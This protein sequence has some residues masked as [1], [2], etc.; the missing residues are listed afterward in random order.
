MDPYFVQAIVTLTVKGCNVGAVN[1]GACFPHGYMPVRIDVEQDAKGDNAKTTE[2]ITLIVKHEN[3][4][5]ESMYSA[6][7]ELVPE[8]QKLSQENLRSAMYTLA[9][10]EGKG[11]GGHD[12]VNEDADE[13][14]DSR[15]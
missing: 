3:Q 14:S 8:F 9:E 5:Q 12:L 6:L 15:K 7:A 11:K 1:I 13:R 2:K 4:M 10:S